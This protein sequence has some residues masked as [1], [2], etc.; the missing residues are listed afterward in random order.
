MATSIIPVRTPEDLAATIELFT[1]YSTALGID[2]SFQD[3]SAEM[4]SMPGKYAPPRGELLLAKNTS[5]GEPIGCVALRPL[6]GHGDHVCEMKRLYVAPAGRGSGAGKALAVTVIQV[7]EKLGYREM[8]LDTLSTMTA[9]LKLYDA[10]GFVDIP[11][12]Y[13]TPLEGTR[14]LSLKL[15]RPPS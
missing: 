10:L 2:L 4:A 13:E 6:S 12:Y 7:A 8:R 11:A 15:L 1:A 9:A 14:F 5:S 3:F